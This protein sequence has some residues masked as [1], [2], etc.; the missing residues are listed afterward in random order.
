MLGE[1]KECELC[2]DFAPKAA[3]KL[4]KVAWEGQ[5]AQKRDLTPGNSRMKIAIPE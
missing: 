1:A 2:A 3:R 4:V 5:L